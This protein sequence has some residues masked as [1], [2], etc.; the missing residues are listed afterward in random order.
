[1]RIPLSR[2]I[3][4]VTVFLCFLFCGLL[5]VEVWALWYL[6]G[7]AVE[8]G[9]NEWVFFQRYALTRALFSSFASPPDV[10]REHHATYIGDLDDDRLWRLFFPADVLLGW[11]PARNIAATRHGKY[12]Y[13]TNSNGFALIGKGNF[14][15]QKPKPPK[16]CRV[17]VIGGSTVFGAGVLSPPENLPAQIDELLQQRQA[18][19]V[20]E[21]I[22][23]G[24]PLFASGQELLYVLSELITYSPDLVI[25]YGGWNDMVVH[26]QSLSAGIEHAPFESMFHASLE[27]RLN[28]S[29]TVTG[30]LRHL[31]GSVKGDS[32][33]ALE[34]VG[35]IRVIEQLVE[36]AKRRV[37]GTAEHRTI[38]YHPASVEYYRRNLDHLIYLGGYYGFKVAIYLQPIMGIDGK[39]LTEEEKQAESVMEDLQL[40]QVFYRDARAMFRKLRAKYACI[41]PNVCIEDVSYAFR[42]IGDMVYTDSGHLT[43][44]GNKVVARAIVDS[45]K[46]CHFF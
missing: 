33:A 18:C 22:N 11:R 41:N 37:F 7:Q 13:A 35:A 8:A 24:V 36:N 25:E 27:R 16:T 38:Q 6:H 10:L 2:N 32:V 17:I 30:N 29:Y 21:V 28:D 20:T 1:M 44:A 15:Y 3:R 14:I 40:R 23:A 26:N 31:L 5:A 34:Q 12:I 42:D 39:V 46:T 45:L 9:Q 4:L 43:L 19:P